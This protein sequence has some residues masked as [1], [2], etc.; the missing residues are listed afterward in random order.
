MCVAATAAAE[1]RGGLG[2]WKCASRMVRWKEEREGK[3][4]R[5]YM[6]KAKS[7]DDDWEGEI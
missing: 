7:I 5:G 1:A 3:G 2:D 4:G 6:T